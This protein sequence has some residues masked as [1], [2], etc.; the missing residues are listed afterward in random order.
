LLVFCTPPTPVNPNLDLLHPY[1]FEKL[2]ALQRSVSPDPAFAP[3]ALSMGEP[4]HTPPPHVVER[5]RDSLHE[6]DRYPATRGIDELRVAICDWL[7]RR[8]ALPPGSVDAERNVL[9]ANG[10]R[11]ALFSFTQCVTGP[12]PER[13]YVAMPNPFY[14]I[15]EGAALLAGLQPAFYDAHTRDFASVSDST[16]RRIQLLFVCTPGNPTGQVLDIGVLQHL[17]EL[18]HRHDFVIASDECYS[19]IY[20]DE[21]RP[22]AG[23]LAAAAANGDTE[24]RRCMVFHSLSKRSNLPGLRSGFVAGDSRLIERFFQYRTYHGCAMGIPVQRASVAAWQDEDHVVENRAL[25]RRKFADALQ[26]LRGKLDVEHPEAGFYLWPRTPGDDVEFARDL[27]ART[28]VTVL[29]GQ[30]LGRDTGHGNPGSGRVRMALV[31]NPE[32]CRIAIERVVEFLHNR[33]HNE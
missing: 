15:Y 13:R 5:L 31:A 30:F 3:I 28:G 19:E 11:E 29:P 24:Y 33:S 27:Y 1:P 4:R 12:D 22:P 32:E 7:T 21:S 9:P 2:A 14:Q 26:V 8:F 6:L 25:Y 10:T 17:L 20:F 18:A 16:W 23:L